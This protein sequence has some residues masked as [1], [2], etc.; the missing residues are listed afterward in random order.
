MQGLGL[1]GQSDAV[2]I[3]LK[4]LEEADTQ[5]VQGQV[6]IALAKIGDARAIKPL[7][8]LLKNPQKPDPTRAI[9]CAGLGLIGDLEFIPSLSRIS[10]DINYRATSDPI[11]EV[12][13]F[14]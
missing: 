5:N 4:E 13:S 14:L 3:L 8:D 2:Q 1:L 10:K 9:S 12:L 11:N 7:V 6:V